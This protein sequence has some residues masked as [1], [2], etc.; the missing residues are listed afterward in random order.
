[1]NRIK[2]HKTL[3]RMGAALSEFPASQASRRQVGSA[4]K[5]QRYI[6]AGVSK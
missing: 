3:L 1:M 2:E 5:F 6:I 4:N